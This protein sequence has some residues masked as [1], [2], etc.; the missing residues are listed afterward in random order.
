MR[1][2][3]GPGDQEARGWDQGGAARPVLLDGPLAPVGGVEGDL[4]RLEASVGRG[5]DPTPARL[6][7]ERR[8]HQERQRPQ[9]GG[10]RARSRSRARRYDAGRRYDGAG[11]RYDDQEEV[12]GRSRS[13]RPV[14]PRSPEA[15]RVGAPRA[16]FGA[17]AAATAAAQGRKEHRRRHRDRQRRSDTP[18]RDRRAR[19]RSRRPRSFSSSSSF[20]DAFS[21][22]SRDSQARLVAWAR[23]HPG[24]LSCRSLQLMADK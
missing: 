11:R 20:R 15:A 16:P 7:E 14:Q 5:R 21:S 18:G 10:R 22:K 12:R 23:K 6:G 1:A 24:L 4:R 3:D 13:R 19:S 9:E 2:A 8:D 17:R